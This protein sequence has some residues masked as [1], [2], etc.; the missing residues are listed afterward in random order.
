MPPH[1]M[2]EMPEVSN[3]AHTLIAPCVP[4]PISSPGS[5]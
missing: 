5:T 3:T 1:T 2:S 4:M